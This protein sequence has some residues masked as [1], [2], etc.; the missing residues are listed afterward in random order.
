MDK[1]SKQAAKSEDV[2]LSGKLVVLQEAASNYSP[3][4]TWAL[5]NARDLELK[6]FTSRKV[7]PGITQGSGQKTKT[8]KKWSFL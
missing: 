7:S 1:E 2:P 5:W 6:P 3:Q 4:K 8:F